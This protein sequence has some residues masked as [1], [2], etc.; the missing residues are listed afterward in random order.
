M[1]TAKFGWTGEMVPVI[2]QGT[3]EIEGPKEQS[4]IDA[5]RAGL[6]LGMT[7]VDTAEMYGSGRSEELVGEA[8]G[9]R[10]DEVFLVTKVLPSNASYDGTLRACERSLQRLGVDQIDLYLLHWESKYPISE[11]MRAFEKLVDDGLTRFIGVSNFDVAHVK[12]AQR[13]LH[14]HRLTA[15]Q[16]LYHLGDRGIERT[17]LPFCRSQEIAVVGYS[18]FGSRGGF[19]KPKS[20]GRK[21]LDEVAARRGLT[22][23][24][25]VLQF[26]TRLAG[27]FTIPKASDAE[28]TRQNGSALEPPLTTQD[29]D[30]IDQ[31][32]PAPDHDVPLGMI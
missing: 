5:L 29:I 19:P 9:T 6:D 1:R 16:V 31:A 18:P 20:A 11:T 28:H 7:H 10:R 8:I 30:A 25:V 26:L 27:V 3:W 12:A 4:A 15:N 21:V 24:Q 14:N 22:P 2:G 17:L 23:H 32:F 13:A